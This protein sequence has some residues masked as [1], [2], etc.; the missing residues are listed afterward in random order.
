MAGLFKT[1]DDVK[2]HVG[3]ANVNND[4]STLDSYID[5]A[6]DSYMCAVM[7]RD[8]YEA[9]VDA[10]Q[11][12]DL[13]NAQ[14]AILKPAQRALANFAYFLFAEDGGLIVNDSGIG[15]AEHGEM[16]RPYQWQVRDFKRNRL[17]I[18]WDA[19]RVLLE[20]LDAGTYTEWASSDE[21][22]QLWENVIWNA[23]TWNK[24]RPIHGQGTLAALQSN[25]RNWRTTTLKANLGVEF[26]DALCEWLIDRTANEHYEALLPYVEKALVFGTL[27]DAV[28]DLP[29]QVDAKGLF[30]DEVDR[31]LQN[32]EMRKK[33]QEAEANK[34]AMI[35]SQ[36][37]RT[38]MGELRE[39]LDN[40]ASGSI[41][42]EYFNSD[43]Y[44]EANSTP[45]DGL[46]TGATFMM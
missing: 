41:F 38:A 7:G 17:R 26:Y 29:I 44:Q 40:V 9:L 35:F 25:I 37:A 6:G 2:P 11:T 30:I 22:K 16:K 4:M 20:K 45:P 33:L 42:P 23:N 27:T 31:G 1:F 34:L 28:F 24:Y 10:F 39:Y 32:D 46:Y 43:N 36:K 21:R 5:T 3:S 12:N 19:V 13:T 14:E 8:T 18:A 15:T